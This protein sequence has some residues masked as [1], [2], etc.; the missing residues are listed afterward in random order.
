MELITRATASIGVKSVRFGT[1]WRHTEPQQGQWNWAPLD[2]LVNAA[3]QAGMEPQLMLSFGGAE[4]TK[5]PES[6]ERARADNAMNR[7]WRY[8]PR[9]ELWREFVRTVANRHRGRVRLREVWNEPDI[10]FFQGTTDQ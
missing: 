2:R 8:P 6:L 9:P 10:G 4:W 1:A 7:Q 5:P 3:T